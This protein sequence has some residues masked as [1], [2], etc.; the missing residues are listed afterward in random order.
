MTPK[1]VA[2]SFLI[3]TVTALVVRLFVV[4]D[5]RISSDSMTPNLL[6]GDLILVSKSAFNL[7]LPFSSFELFRTGR[8]DRSEVVAFSVPERGTDTYVK[9]IVALGG[10][11]V[12]IKEGALWIN[13]QMAVYQEMPDSTEVTE[14]W[15]TGRAYQINR[16]KTQMADYGPVDVP[17]DHFFALGDNRLDSVDSRTWGPVPYSCLKGRVALVWLSVG[18]SG[19]VRSSRWLSSIQ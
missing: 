16:G 9:R 11:R 5:F 3:A 19:G 8:P 7:R 12:E 18:N 6:K 14:K 2:K 17:A 4:E 10:D 13:G 15:P 1:N